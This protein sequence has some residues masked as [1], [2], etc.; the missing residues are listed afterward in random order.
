MDSVLKYISTLHEVEDWFYVAFGDALNL[1]NLMPWHSESLKDSS[2]YCDVHALAVHGSPGAINAIHSDVAICGQ[3]QGS[4]SPST[5]SIHCNVLSKIFISVKLVQSY[6]KHLYDQP[7]AQICHDISKYGIHEVDIA[8]GLITWV[9]LFLLTNHMIRLSVSF[10]HLQSH[11]K[12]MVTNCFVC[13]LRDQPF[14][15]YI[16]TK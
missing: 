6:R 16:R 2:N 15:Q 10:R 8:F 9:L 11:Y 12:N 5:C 13:G 3:V 14:A 4:D 1:K 7:N